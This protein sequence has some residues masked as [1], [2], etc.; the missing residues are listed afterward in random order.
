MYRDASNYKVFESVVLAG[1]LLMETLAPC[2]GTI[3][4][5]REFIPSQVGLEDLQ[6][7]MLS[8]PSA[9]DHVWHE[10]ESVELTSSPVTK[11]ELSA[12]QLLQNFRDVQGEWNVADA[13][14]KHGFTQ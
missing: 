6:P 4:T 1:E 11:P 9:D 10:L 14:K 5:G 8:Y 12:A 2:L 13:C 7:R 3:S